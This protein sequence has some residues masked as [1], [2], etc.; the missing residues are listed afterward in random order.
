MKINYLL[1]IVLFFTQSLVAQDTLKNALK[2]GDW[3]AHFPYRN[4]ISV[5]TSDQAV[6]W[7][8]GLS[9]LK[10]NKSDLS[11]ERLDKLNDL[12]DAEAT[13]VRF[14]RT[15]KKLLVVYKNTN[16][17]LVD[18]EG[19]VKTKSLTDIRNNINITGDKTIFDVSFVGDT[20]YLAC[21]F[22][23]T[24][25][26]MRKGEFISTVFLRQKTYATVVFEGKIWAATE[27]GI[28]TIAND[29]QV[30][31][32]DFSKWK[33]LSETDGF[34]KTYRSKA[35]T[36]FDNKIY[37][38]VNDTLKSFFGTNRP[39]SIRHE[40]GFDIKFLSGNATNL[41]MV[42]NCTNNC[43]GKALQ[44][45]KN[46][47]FR[48]LAANCLNRPLEALQDAD[49][50]IWFAELYNGFRWLN[51]ATDGACNVREYD[52]PYSLESFNLAAND[53]SVWLAYGGLRGINATD[54]GNCFSTLNKFGNWLNYNALY[55][56]ILVDSNVFRDHLA[57]TIH[58]KNGKTYVGT[59]NG[60]LVEVTAGKISKIYNK[61]NSAIRASTAD[62]GRQRITGM[63]FDKNANLWVVN[64]L[65]DR[66]L[67][68]WR[69]DGVWTQMS[70]LP[71]SNLFQLAIDGSGF[72]WSIVK[73][74]Q[75]ALVVFDEGKNINDPAD[76]RAR[77]IDNT[78]FPKDIQSASVNCIASDLDGRIWVGTSSGVMY[79]ACGG[80]PFRATCVGQLVISSLSGISEYL[81]K[82]K[83]VNVIAV[84]GANRKWFGTSAGLFVTSADGREEVLK[85]NVENSPLPSNNITALAIRPNG[86]VFIGTDRGLMSYKGDATEGGDF[87]KTVDKIIAYP[88]PIRP[89]YE[90]P[91]AIK[92]F[93]RD[94]NIK[95]T[96]VNGNAVFETKALG[97]Q[98]I[99]DGKDFNGN[100]VT[101]GV[102]LVLATNTRNLD[103]PE[104]VVAKLLFVR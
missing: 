41:L 60:G 15:T 75:S 4:G 81:L 51:R 40:T 55:N 94:A 46:G 66:A 12:N 47:A 87:N 29:P 62:P 90:G 49:G 74:S 10:L 48:T 102:Y 45:D 88:N 31:F 36:V 76:D 13:L 77:L 98:A 20:A 52:S 26:D 61:S 43:N 5:T 23:I 22:G 9:V 16:I 71:S 70:P 8:T 65:A 86:E 67:V 33:Q 6:Y 37:A 84:D 93:A 34:P 54:N 1:P 44:L 59:F 64:N 85:F 27:G 30:N 56:Q 38:D 83:S 53:T 73:G 25:L 79:F 97:G 50:K 19:G 72:K 57:V 96:D 89:D 82:D 42:L 32:N 58:P 100:R 7:A 101:T 95:I 80:D 68:V 24:R 63:A 28:F 17:D 78:S 11:I 91:I 39:L 18:T 2:I 69:N 104:A 103:A 35:I 21:G 99:W 14:N 92:G 3:R